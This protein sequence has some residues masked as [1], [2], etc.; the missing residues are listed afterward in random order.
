MEYMHVYVCRCAATLV[1]MYIGMYVC[2]CGSGRVNL[3][4]LCYV[5]AGEESSSHSAATIR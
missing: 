3:F 5:M 2:L 4:W 1:G